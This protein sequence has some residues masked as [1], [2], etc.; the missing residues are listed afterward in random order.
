VRRVLWDVAHGAEI[1]ITAS[2]EHRVDRRYVEQG[3]RTRLAAAVKAAAALDIAAGRR[4]RAVQ[5]Q[6]I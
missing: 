6:R 2:R 5:A 1:V 3:V 4:R